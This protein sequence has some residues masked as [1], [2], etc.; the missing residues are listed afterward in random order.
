MLST[1]VEAGEFRRFDNPLHGRRLV[2]LNQDD[3][4]R[5]G[6]S[7]GDHELN[8]QLVAHQFASSRLV[9]Q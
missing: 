7:V 5:I 8:T 4:D 6:D 9:V 3:V 2:K 1:S